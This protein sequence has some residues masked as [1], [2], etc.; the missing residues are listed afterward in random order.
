MLIMPVMSHATITPRGM[1]GSHFDHVAEFAPKE[2]GSEWISKGMH[3]RSVK[4]GGI[5]HGP[6]ATQVLHSTNIQLHCNLCGTP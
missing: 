4:D 3:V 1:W 2:K 5:C 6:P